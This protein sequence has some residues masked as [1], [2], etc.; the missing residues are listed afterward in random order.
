M[1]RLPKRQE[2]NSA[3]LLLSPCWGVSSCNLDPESLPTQSTSSSSGHPGPAGAEP[4]VSGVAFAHHRVRAVKMGVTA[5][6][7]P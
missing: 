3:V 4:V 1:A 6:G 2:F 7:R 5:L